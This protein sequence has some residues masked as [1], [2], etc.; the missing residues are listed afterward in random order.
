MAKINVGWLFGAAAI[1]GVGWLLMQGKARAARRA[2]Q[3][4]FEQKWKIEQEA[5]AEAIPA[6]AT[7][8][9]APFMVDWLIAEGIIDATAV[10]AF[11][12]PTIDA[13]QKVLT[14]PGGGTVWIVPPSMAGVEATPGIFDLDIDGGIKG[15]G[16][17][18]QY[19]EV[20]VSP[21]G[22]GPGGTDPTTI[23]KFTSQKP[24]QRAPVS[25]VQPARPWTGTW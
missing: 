8:S 15:Y 24:Q 12:D 5:Y 14:A 4:A 3:R 21:D 19:W 18:S 25:F 9:L 16:G 23:R 11:V 7:Q 1:G 20:P 10:D 6:T 2:R 17:F 22:I 13:P